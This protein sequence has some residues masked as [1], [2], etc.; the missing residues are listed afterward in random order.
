MPNPMAAVLFK[1][2]N[3]YME[4]HSQEDWNYAAASQGI[5]GSQETG[6]EQ[7]LS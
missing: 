7:R 2:R 5:T 3:L 1:K 6:P 4:T